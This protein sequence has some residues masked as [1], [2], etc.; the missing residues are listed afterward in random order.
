GLVK[1][2]DFMK[3]EYPDELGRSSFALLNEEFRKMLNNEID[4]FYG[5]D[6]KHQN[7]ITKEV[8]YL[9]HHTT[10][11][12]RHPD[13]ILKIVGGYVINNTD[14]LKLIEERRIM[15][16]EKEKSTRA[17]R[18][19]I[20]SGRMML[21]YLDG[22]ELDSSKYFY[23]NELL[24]SKLGLTEFERNKFKIDEF[25]QSIFDG[26]EEGRLLKE[27]Y[28]NI[29]DRVENNELDSYDKLLVKHQN[30][31]T[32]EIFYFEHSFEVESRF[33]DGRLKIRG[34]YMTD[35]TN[36]IN[37]KKRNEFL[38]GHDAVTGL[39]NRNAF[40]QFIHSKEM[41][42]MYTIVIADIDGL[43]LINDAFG[44]LRGDDAI[45]FVGNQ[46]HT[47]FEDCSTIYRIGGDEFAVISREIDEFEIIKKLDL[48]KENI[49]FFNTKNEIQVG[50]SIGYEV[51]KKPNVDFSETFTNAE[52]LMYRQKLRDRN[53]RK[54]K[55]M[56]AVLET[57]HVKTEETKEHCDRLGAYAK[58]TLIK[59]GLT[60]NS[61][62]DDIEILCQVHDIG[63]ITISEEILSKKGKLTQEEYTKIKKHSEAGYK[64]IKNIVDSDNIALGVLFHHEKVD[65]TGYPFGLKGDEIP[66]FA[67]I[68]SVCDAYD[69]MITGRKYSKAMTVEAALEEIIQ[70]TGTQFDEKVSSV[71]IEMIQESFTK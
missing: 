59:M 21:W 63:K 10:V 66:L 9:E 2:S 27:K 24:F 30:I 42:A 57:L 55:T 58:K 14:K 54:S 26:D 28:F 67:K 36:E 62:L 19:A 5:R 64:I 22:T 44:H 31:I 15:E 3:T 23:G 6:I 40:E 39:R 60:R 56:D 11:E 51:I 46:F 37:L 38:I 8:V 71:F 49:T 70:C 41:P 53:S 50:V 20:K 35:V 52:N 16:L 29:D 48:I 32:H 4:D 12:E 25:N 69:V 17:N 18:L 68:I 45:A 65:G 61:D 43:K 33:D 47:I 34:G 1:Q 7:L 13:G